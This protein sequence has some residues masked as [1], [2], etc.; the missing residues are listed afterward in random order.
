MI[1]RVYVFYSH[2]LVSFLNWISKDRV[3]ISNL[4]DGS[5]RYLYPLYI[6]LFDCWMFLQIVSCICF[7]VV[8]FAEVVLIAK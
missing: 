5:Y 2:I 4:E 7:F 6:L 3:M 1:E 8:W